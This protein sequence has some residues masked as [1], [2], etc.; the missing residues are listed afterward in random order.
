MEWQYCKCEADAAS[1]T[2][3][4]EFSTFSGMESHGMV[5]ACSSLLVWIEKIPEVL[6][7]KCMKQLFLSW[8]IFLEK[9]FKN[10]CP[11]HEDHRIANLGA[12]GKFM[13]LTSQLQSSYP[14]QSNSWPTILFSI[15]TYKI[16]HSKAKGEFLYLGLHNPFCFIQI[17]VF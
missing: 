10:N 5:P 3:W 16:S 4:M 2:A 13:G 15:Q 11:I 17:I 12:K 6:I 14:R 1:V 9:C 7:I 8:T